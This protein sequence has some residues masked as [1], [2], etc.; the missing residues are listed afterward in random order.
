MIPKESIF[1]S[2]ATASGICQSCGC[3]RKKSYPVTAR[4]MNMK[5]SMNFPAS[6]GATLLNARCRA[7]HTSAREPR[8]P[9]LD[10]ALAS[11]VM[12]GLNKLG[13]THEQP[14]VGL[15]FGHL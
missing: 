7:A 12:R 11:D 2:W 5:L 10:A 4:W 14:V 13:G 3:C 9:C 8:A 6:D 1:M 15:T